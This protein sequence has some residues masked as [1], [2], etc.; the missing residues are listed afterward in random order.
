MRSKLGSFLNTTL[1]LST[2]FCCRVTFFC[3]MF[4]SISHTSNMYSPI[5]PPYTQCFILIHIPQQ[6]FL[7]EIPFNESSGQT[8]PLNF[9]VTHES[10]YLVP[11]NRRFSQL[12]QCSGGC[13][14]S[15]IVSGFL[16]LNVQLNWL[17]R[18]WA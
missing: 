6:V 14:S 13:S 1:P 16:C 10:L 4:V 7:F 17:Y 2:I 5:D 18:D 15:L 8:N 9:L 3:L 12:P 11:S